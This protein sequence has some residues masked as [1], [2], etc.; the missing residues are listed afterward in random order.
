[1]DAIYISS[2]TEL[3]SLQSSITRAFQRRFQLHPPFVERLGLERELEVKRKLSDIKIRDLFF[4]ANC[5]VPLSRHFLHTKLSLSYMHVFLNVYFGS[6]LNN[7]CF[8]IQ[9]TIKCVSFDYHVYE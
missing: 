3:F 2:F 9:S 4:T 5:S 6:V 8:K 7:L 1:M